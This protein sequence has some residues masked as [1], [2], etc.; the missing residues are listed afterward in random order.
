MRIHITD[1]YVIT[2]DPNNYILN[3]AGLIKSGKKAGQEKLEA[4]GFYPTLSELV[5]G[6]IN[7][8]LRNSQA[9]SISGLERACTDLCGEIEAL[10]SLKM[11]RKI[12][13]PCNKCEYKPKKGKKQ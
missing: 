5:A 3:E 13:I 4:V 7:R 10:F 11:D 9:R 2:T 12:D 1:K 6:L 8:K